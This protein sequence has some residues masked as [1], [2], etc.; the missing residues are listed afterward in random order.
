MGCAPI[1]S[2]MTSSG[3][4]ATAKRSTGC[5]TTKRSRLVRRGEEFGSW[6]YEH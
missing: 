5:L 6:R 2:T 1:V 3:S 4:M